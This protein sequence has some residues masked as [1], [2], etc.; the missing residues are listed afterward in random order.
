MATALQ[1][2]V[3]KLRE[4]EQQMQARAEASERLASEMVVDAI[5]A[6]SRLREE[7]A[8]RLA[9]AEGSRTPPP[10]KRRSVIPM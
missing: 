5:V 9:A 10:R 2:A 4:Q 1:E 3:G 8:A 6:P 7:V